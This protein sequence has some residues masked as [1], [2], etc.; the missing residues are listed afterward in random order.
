MSEM[1]GAVR[2]HLKVV[3]AQGPETFFDWQLLQTYIDLLGSNTIF[4]LPMLEKDP[5]ITVKENI[6]H[7]PKGHHFSTVTAF[8]NDPCHKG[9]MLTYRFNGTDEG[10]TCADHADFTRGTGAADQAMSLGLWFNAYSSAA[11]IEG[12]ITKIDDQV[13]TNVEWELYL[14]AAG[15]V[16]FRTHDD[17]VPAH[18]GRRYN[19]AISDHTWYFVCATKSTG[20]TSAAVDI[21][22]AAATAS[23]ISAV[24]D[25]NVQNG[26]YPLVL[27]V[28]YRD[29]QYV[30][31]SFNV[32]FYVRVE[33]NH[34]D[35]STTD[36]TEGL[37][38]PLSEIGLV[39]TAVIAMSIVIIILYRRRS[40]HSR[41]TQNA[42]GKTEQ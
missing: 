28:T 1:Y 6:D 29:D 10:L 8:D 4:F 2:K 38:G 23:S 20:I 27:K 30:D 12:L 42:L 35:Q 32:T 24:D 17:S 25:T 13:A 14:D 18:I 26:T 5:A 16:S 34:D 39:L 22:L 36:G 15:K 11:A 41:R 37:L 33:K 40:L 9:L 31:H 19:T 7:G 21:Y 3:S